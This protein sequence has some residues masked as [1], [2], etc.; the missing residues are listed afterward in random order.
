MPFINCKTNR[1]MADVKI[2]VAAIKTT[3]APGTIGGN[4]IFEVADKD[5]NEVD[6]QVSGI[7]EATFQLPVGNYRARVYRAEAG[8]DDKILGAPSIARFAV[9]E[10]APVLIDT[11]GP[12]KIE[13]LT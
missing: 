1:I 11:A 3:H 7:Q 6:Q 5:G 4:W 2:T 12:L 13:Q 10:V 8:A 9:V